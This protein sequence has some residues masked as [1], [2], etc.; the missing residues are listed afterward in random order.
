MNNYMKKVT[1]A[2]SKGQLAIL[3]GVAAGSVLGA[4]L[5]N[6]SRPVKL[7]GAA[8]LL[9]GGQIMNHALMT[10][11][12]VGVLVS[13]PAL[14]PVGYVGGIEGLKEQAE[15]MIAGSRNQAA[16]LLSEL[17]VPESITNAVAGSGSVNGWDEYDDLDYDISGTLDEYEDD[18]FLEEG[19]G[20]VTAEALLINGGVVSTRPMTHEA[21]LVAQMQGR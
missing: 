3:G 11:M 2:K 21:M 6:V 7:A 1:T 13:P 8:A 15:D 9:I 20:S 17:Y 10:Q 18:Y 4:G 5:G 12:G 14:K 16:A 19:V